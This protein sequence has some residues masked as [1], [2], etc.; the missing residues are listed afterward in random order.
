VNCSIL[1]NGGK[2]MQCPE[3]GRNNP[4]DTWHCDCGYDFEEKRMPLSKETN[5][6]NNEPTVKNDGL[7]WY[8]RVRPAIEGFAAIVPMYN[9]TSR[10]RINAP[11]GAVLQKTFINKDIKI[12]RCSECNEIHN[13]TKINIKSLVFKYMP[14][15]LLITTILFLIFFKGTKSVIIKMYPIF[16]IFSFSILGIIYPFFF[17]R[18]NKIKSESNIKEYAEIAFHRRG[19]WEFGKSPD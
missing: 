2:V 1:A 11:G 14:L 6:P 12:P 4:R 18:K 16:V 5:S 9:I 10:V 15:T 3:C 7:C 17:S 13:T 8:C 19:G